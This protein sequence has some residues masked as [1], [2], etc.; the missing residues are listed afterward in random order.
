[1][2]KTMEQTQD[3]VPIVLKDSRKKKKFWKRWSTYAIL[4]GLLGVVG[5]V[6][7]GFGGNG[8]AQ[9]ET[10]V[11]EKR[12]LLRTV[13]LT[14]EIKPSVRLNLAF[15]RSGTLEAV[16]VEVGEDVEA[17]DVIAV[18]EDR[19]VQFAYQSA[20]AALSAAQAKLDLEIA[21][22]KAQTIEKAEASVDQARADLQKAESELANMKLTVQDEIKSAE[23]AVQTA[24][25]NVTNQ[26]AQL[27][28]AVDDAIADAVVILTNALGPMDSALTEGDQI[29]GVDDT[30][31]NSSYKHLLGVTTAGSLQSAK[32]SYAVAKPVKVQ[33]EKLVRALTTS[34]DEDS[35]ENA[36]DELLRALSLVQAYLVDVQ[37]VLSGT[38]TGTA[39]SSTQLSTL[40][41]TISTERT[42]LSTQYTN[43]QNAIQAITNA[44]LD[45][46]DTAQSLQDAYETAVLNLNI[47]KTNAETSVRTAE[48][49]VTVKQAALRAAEADLDLMKSPPRN[50]DL[51]PLRAAVS[52]A[53]VALNQTEADMKKIQIIAPINGT[54]SDIIP[55]V[56]ELITA[57]NPAVGLI[58]DELFDI[59]ALIPEADV[60][61]VKIGQSA[62][63]TLD[64]YG[65]DIP[66]SGTVVSEDPDQTLVQDAVYYKSRVSVDSDDHEIKP[67]MT[68]NVTVLISEQPDVLVIPT[69]SV[70]T[71]SETRETRVRI[72]E[73]GKVSE[74]TIKL[75]QRGDE[76]RIAVTSGLREGETIIVSERNN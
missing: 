22:E 47:A 54:I 12:N 69:R 15:E 4:T 32:D 68:A 28:Q 19:D 75:G 30:A 13:E 41:S 18:L 67:G 64:A 3:Q 71:D 46:T 48:S 62:T 51:E 10:F 31:T 20:R 55:E 49:T 45:R 9:Y 63:V 29:I 25:N 37:S 11:V 44:R 66:F 40:K 14:G 23:I 74:R 59:E 38:L 61:Q 53:R 72:L 16:L 17:G 70:I 60:A 33:A 57:N 1:M 26:G 5:L 2:K 52:E 35:V 34:S 65:D 27:D 73:N 24:Q 42:A 58:S 7:W 43:V 50:V 36:A 39:L 21:G 8:N 6:I 76:G 56:G